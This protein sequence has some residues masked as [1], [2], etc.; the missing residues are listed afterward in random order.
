MRF[1]NPLQGA[2]RLRRGLLAIA[3]LALGS[4]PAFMAVNQAHAAAACQ[5]GY[6]NVNQWN[7]GFQIN[8]TIT[9]LGDPI[10]SWTL[11]WD[12]ANGQTI[13]QLWNGNA[14]QTGTHV[15][16]TNVA[17]NGS[18]GTGKSDTS[19][20]FTGN[21]NGATTNA[22][23]TTFK[24][25]GTTCSG[26]TPTPTPTPSGTPSPTPTPTPTPTP[27]GTPTPTPTP[28]PSGPPPVHPA[29]PFP[30]T[31]P[32]LN[33]DYQA[34]VQAQ[35]TADNSAAEAKVATWQTAIWMDR[36]A[37]IT[38][39][40]THRGLQAQLDNAVSQATAGTP[41][42]F[43][44]VIYDLP[45]RD[46][47]ALASNG[48]IPATSAGLTDYETNYITPIATILSNP[49]YSAIRIVAIIEPD[50]LP[51][52]VTNQN[53]SACSTATP[54]YE[55]GIAF[56]LNKL[57]AIPNVWNFV[58]IAHSAWLGWPNN[59]TAAGPEFAKVANATT[60]KFQ[61]IDGFASDT[62]NYTPTVEPFLPTNNPTMQVGGQQ[63]NSAKFYSFNV[64]FDENTYDLNMYNELVSVGFPASIGFVIDTSRNGW[65]GP[66]R[67]TAVN[68]TPTTP[69]TYVAANK[70]DM[71]AFRGNWCNQN[72][73]GIG[74]IP[75]ANPSGVNA[76]IFAFVWVKP[77]G[78]SDGDYPTATHT[79]G[80]PHCDPNST[81]TDGNGG[82]FPTG[83]IPGFDIPAGQFFPAQFQQLVKNSFPVIQ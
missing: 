59:T 33:P 34:E 14:T 51:N 76:H 77:P 23:P 5:I 49:K 29:N 17:F 41:T 10:T 30:G 62:A 68:S 54:F 67:P 26:A 19:V 47:A 43:E 8:L 18:I 32:Y 58:D 50:S 82:V 46:C 27:S 73:A 36:K 12:F 80:D 11:E 53:L 22:V 6:A 69:D 78:E 4:V 2:T 9:N 57:H 3:T 21:L 70:T 75:Q 71:R 63:L 20:G 31:K 37:A 39:D 13:N 15:T 61:S 55:Q 64:T 74:A 7:T 28:T 79:H 72:G 81:N 1:F 16:V 56:A 66:S 35:A 25:N 60:A 42:L 40:A 38:G 45:G 44:V 52:A 24:L 83:S 65:G 48:E